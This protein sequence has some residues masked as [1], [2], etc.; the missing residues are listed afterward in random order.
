MKRINRILLML[1]V[2]AV[3]ILPALGQ[4]TSRIPGV[5]HVNADG[6][7][8]FERSGREILLA[9]RTYYIRPDGNDNNTG[10]INDSANAWRTIQHGVDVV[11]RNLDLGRHTVT[12]QLGDGT[13]NESIVVQGLVGSSVF[14]PALIIQGNTGNNAAVV[15]NS[16]GHGLTAAGNSESVVNIR[17]LTITA[18]S[19]F[20]LSA[21]DYGYITFDNLIFG[22]AVVHIHAMGISRITANDDY[23]I[24]GSA[25]FHMAAEDS[26]FIVNANNTI[27][28]LGTPSFSAYAYA[29]KLGNMELRGCTFNGTAN[30]QRFSAWGNSVI[31]TEGA[32]A[33]YLP[34]SVA[35]TLQTGG[36]YF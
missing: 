25:T 13:Y 19:G 30:G 11:G 35:G 26:S 2:A 29:L 8:V 9:N 3:S 5:E 28:L 18:P 16:S 1:C 31:N 12:L 36:L 20:C 33:N 14:Q 21:H 22:S 4:V 32:G 27:T 24:S 34:G 23:A 17:C 15:I 10:L 6:S 7:S